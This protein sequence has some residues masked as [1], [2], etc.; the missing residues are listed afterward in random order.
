[1]TATPEGIGRAIIEDLLARPEFMYYRVGEVASIHY[2]EA[3]AALGALRLAGSLKD[4]VLVS[5]LKSRYD[6]ELADAEAPGKVVNTANH[7]DANVYGIVPLEIY[8]RTGD[9]S[10]LEQGL[11][12]ADSQWEDPLPKG[13]TRQT[14]YWVDDVYMIA[15]LQAEAYDATL[16]ASYL[17]RAALEVEEYLRVLQRP[18]GLFN[19][20]EEA[21]F[22]WGRGNGWVA[23]GLAELLMRLPK[24][25]SRYE[26]IE[27]GYSRMMGTLLLHQCEDGMWRQL[28]DDASSWKE[29]S[30]SAMFGFALRVGVR[31]GV[32]EAE[33]FS[34]SY[35]KAWE[36]LADLVGADGKL[37][38]IC[39]GTGQSSERSYYLERPRVRGDLHG[40][41]AMLW[42]C[43]EML[44]INRG[45]DTRSPFVTG[46]PRPSEPG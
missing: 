17:E 1:V 25:D 5:R 38:G 35:E 20:G 34:A 26:A 22:A 44:G 18:D 36:A 39:A 14:R 12:L 31:L 43:G 45:I 24:A 15:S 28:V 6:I 19:H 40:Q 3:C 33:E 41:A 11:A 23:A 29:A 21:P 27:S 30:A 2:A 9:S 13:M 42:L 4:E 32:L 46:R 7:V 8:A 16:N 10:F 37:S